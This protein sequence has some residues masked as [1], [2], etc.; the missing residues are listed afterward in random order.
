MKNLIY[1]FLLFST[2]VSSQNYNYAIDGPQKIAKPTGVNNQPEEIAYFN[3][4]LLPLSQKAN[5]QMAL[6]TYGAVRL[7]KG[8]YSGVKVVMHSN[9]R[10][11]GH[12]STNNITSI[13][14]AAGSTNVCIESLKPARDSALEINFQSGAVISN[15]TFKTLRGAH[16][17]ATNSML[18]N[19]TFIDINGQIQFDCSTSGYFRNNKI[20]KQQ[21]GSSDVLVMKG[22]RTTLSYG[23]VTLHSNYLGTE[24]NTTDIDN[25]ENITLIG[26]DAETYWGLNR[27]M[28]HINNVDKVKL[29]ITNGNISYES[30]FP[31]SSIDANEVYSISNSG[32]SSTTDKLAL[33]TNLLSF[34]STKDVNRGIGT[35]TGY[36]AKQYPYQVDRDFFQNF[37][38]NSVNKTATITDSPTIYNLTN[39]ILGTK[40]TPKPWARPTWNT[41]PDPLGSTWAT[42]RKGKTDSTAY[43]QNLINTNGVA[44]LPEGIFY[45]SSTLNIV[46]DGTHGIMGKGTGKTV[47]CGLTD[48]F[49]LISVTSGDFGGIVLGY[50]TLQGG[51]AGI[52]ESNPPMMIS[53]QSIK[54]ISFRNQAVGMHFK[55]IYAVDNNFF[56]NLAFTNCTTGIFQESKPTLF[57]PNDL[58]GSTYLDKNVFYN[59]QFINCSIGM[60]LHSIR[61]SNLNAWVDCKFDGGIKASDMSGETVIFA[62]CDFTHYT[63]DYTIRAN[64]LNLLSCN[65]YNNSNVKANLYSIGNQIEGCNF[66]DNIPLSDP[67]DG[68]PVVNMVFNSTITGRAF[69]PQ[70]P[71]SYRNSNSLF[72]NS[73]LLSNPI[74]SK[75]LVTAVNDV[76]TVLLNGTPNPYPQFLVTQ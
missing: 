17:T 60:N 59:C 72:V 71:I 74:F 52:Y 46:N 6:D 67:V 24:R 73:N 61:A 32:G 68:N 40:V 18:E 28:L 42:D 30:G 14:I 41:M 76:P 37:A 19:N 22:N 43:I 3:A 65:F 62:N 39:S 70:D 16:I 38:Y 4:Y 10:L 26:T 21:S 8:D 55:E 7:E 27:E 20:I 49:P 57:N 13:T 25:L 2:V 54:Y 23:N 58:N 51:N 64:G 47:I 69:V 12:I 29:M 63:G 9:Q 15:C 11:Y 56:E 44:D 50:M 1:F 36:F 53:F 35:V 5:L 48:D 45:I 33:R 31:F 66:L 75:L 34:N